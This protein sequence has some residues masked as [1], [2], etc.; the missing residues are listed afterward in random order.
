MCIRDRSE[1]ATIDGVY[2]SYIDFGEGYTFWNT[3]SGIYSIYDD[4][5]HLLQNTGFTYLTKIDD[6]HYTCLLYTSQIL[7]IAQ[8]MIFKSG[9]CCG[10]P[11]KEISGIQ[12]LS[13]THGLSQALE[14]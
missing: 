5:G 4:A 6:D 1:V 8:Q 7:F 13:S 11:V 10:L 14:V 2:S 12:Q 9:C 3:N